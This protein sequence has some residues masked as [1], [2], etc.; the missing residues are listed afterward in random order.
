MNKKFISFRWKLISTYLLLSISSIIFI[1]GIAYSFMIGYF[2]DEKIKQLTEQTRNYAQEMSNNLAGQYELHD[3]KVIKD[4]S[5]LLKNASLSI[6]SRFMFIDENY[7]VLVDAYDDYSGK[8]LPDIEEVKKSNTGYT[9]YNV[10]KNSAFNKVV[11]IAMPI[12]VDNMIKGSVLV[13]SSL[14][15]VY[16]NIAVLGAKFIVPFVISIFIFA[17]VGFAFSQYAFRPI[18]RFINAI[19]NINANLK[20]EKVEID[21]NDE[22]SELAEQFNSMI[23]KIEQVDERRDKFV[24]NVSHELRS[25][26]ASIKIISETLSTSPSDNIEVYQDFM[27]DINSELTRLSKIIDTLLNLVKFDKGELKLE[28]SQNNLNNLVMRNINVLKP[29]ADKKNIAITFHSK[30]ILIANVDRDKLSQ[31]LINIVNNA[32]KYTQEGGKINVSLF[33]RK[34]DIAIEI[35]DTGMGIPEKDFDNIFDR[36]YRVDEARARDTGGTGL[37]LSIAQQIMK[38]HMGNIELKSVLKEGSTFTLVLPKSV[39]VKS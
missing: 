23:N 19:K 38:L 35:A 15:D 37:G 34:D 28:F 25:P 3:E 29:M 24:S 39:L 32:I 13:V 21:S 17:G 30:E 31:A 18:D 12:Y 33:T 14:E 6:N 2:I 20:Y 16:L 26:I 1:N 5:D 9:S 4:I 36:F 22:F 8:V 10:Y 11:Y 27:L 7:R